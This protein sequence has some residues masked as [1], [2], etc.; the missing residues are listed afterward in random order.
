MGEVF[1]ARHFDDG[2]KVAIK[3]LSQS[4]TSSRERGLRFE[5]ES[6]LAI[7]L[8]HPNIVAVLGYG[9]SDGRDYLVMELVEGGS[10]RELLKPG[11]PMDVPTVRTVLRGTVQA[12]TYLHDKRIIHRDLKP[13]NVLVDGSGHVKVTDFG[14]AVPVAEVGAVTGT[15]EY[16]GTVDYMAPEQRAR[17]PID[18]RADQFS[19]GVI[20]YE[21]LTGKRPLGSFKPASHFNP[22]LCSRVDEVLTTALREDSDD[23]YATVQEFW[24]ALAQAL[25]ESPRRWSGRWVAAAA[26]VG[27]LAAGAAAIANHLRGRAKDTPTSAIAENAGDEREQED[28]TT[29]DNA[30]TGSAATRTEAETAERVQYFM[31]L[32]DEHL[33]HGRDRDAEIAYT[34]AIRLASRNPEPRLKRAFLYKKI[35]SIQKSLDELDEALRIDPNL[36]IARSGRGSIYVQLKD[37]PRAIVELDE[38]TRLDPQDAEAFAYRGWAHHNLHNDDLA[39]AD[40]NR[41]VDLD[42]NCFV[43]YQFRALWAKSHDD[44]EQARADFQ[45]AIRCDPNNPYAN[46]GLALLL[47]TCK[48]E[49]FRDGKLAVKHAR[50]ACEITGWREWQQ[51]RILASAHAQDGDLAAAIQRCE[52][53]IQLA[54]ETSHKSLKAQLAGYRKRAGQATGDSEP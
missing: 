13:E 11:Q 1:L 25:A 43:A 17:L 45:D 31:Q 46:S 38:A 12:L 41:S 23:R 5:R 20:A 49:S 39:R 47:A 36:A 44:H 4:V 22:R 19:L 9:Q 51:I 30:A 26:G 21:M 32:G 7:E 18:E 33:S 34:E 8:I 37:F 54:P 52:E 27:L 15:G 24:N 16:I 10:L 35:E 48:D 50:K 14:L 2:R 29:A 6:R 3:F 42:S 40:L 28:A 53:A